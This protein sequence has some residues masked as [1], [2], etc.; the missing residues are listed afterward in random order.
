MKKEIIVNASK[1]RSRIAIVEDGEL[2]EL[3]VE[4]PD[5]VRTLG[6]IYLAR[7][8]KVMPAIRA[9]FVDIG[10]KQDAF[11]H[12]SDLTD[13]LAELLAITGDK[14]PGQKER[15]LSTAP[16]KRIAD[17]ADEPDVE[18]TLELD[19]DEKSRQGNRRSSRRGRSNRGRSH[20]RQHR[21]RQNEEEEEQEETA[22]ATPFV[23]DLT[24]KPKPPPPKPVVEEAKPEPEIVEP[25]AEAPEP[26]VEVK[27]ERKP[28]IGIG[29]I[30]LTSAA[31]SKKS[32]KKKEDRP[33]P[34]SE[35]RRSNRR[36]EAVEIEEED[37]VDEDDVVEA[38]ETDSDDNAQT[39]DEE[40]DDRRRGRRR[41]RRGGRRRGRRSEDEDADVSDDSSDVEEPDQTDEDEQPRQHS[42]RNRGGRGRSSSKETDEAQ[43]AEPAPKSN[44]R[45][46][47]S[48][49]SSRR[50][51]NDSR[52]QDRK[53]SG[54]RPSGPMARPDDMLKRDGRI[55]VKVTKEP[56][57]AKGSRVSTDISFAGRFLVLV[58]AADY[59]AV[60]KKIESARER[61]RLRTLAHSLKPDG[62]GV[63]VRTVATGKDAKTLDT[64]LSLLLDKWRKIEATLNAR[65]D[66]PE[67]LYEDVNM[68]SSI[69][70]DL[71]TDDFDRIVVDDP[72]LH[73]NIK[74][75]V[76]AV[77][78][79]MAEKVKLH[80]SNT[81]LFRAAGIERA[82]EQVFSSRV[83]LPSGGYLIVEHTEAMHVVDVN[84]GRAGKGKTQ[85]ENLLSVNLEAAHEVARQLR[86]RDLGGII[87]ID[88][89]DMYHEGDRRK[90]YQALKREFMKDRA[91]TKLLPMS[92]F[93]LIEITR[94]RLRPSITAQGADGDDASSAME[95]AGASEI[96]QPKRHFGPQRL[97]EP[98]S[99]E[100]IAVHID[101]WLKNYSKKVNDRY[102]DRPVVIRVHPLLET[103]LKKGIFNRMLKWRLGVKGIKFS[104]E[105]NSALHPLDFDACDKKS[106]KS[107]KARFT[108]KQ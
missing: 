12:F 40:Y 91:V 27:E 58:P 75:Y 99:H 38:V 90:V 105:T 43:V 104:F 2:A 88:F 93:G 108:P 3:Y 63:I 81:P 72:K 1:D 56:I 44:G 8:R 42:S 53:S 106:G 45:S 29:T 85:A 49:S 55:L 57:S 98:V 33:A 103:Y 46:S 78:P 37:L 13:N 18:D 80:R 28:V 22:G 94:Q 60:S 68:V 16:P 71:F 67:L 54:N 11:L 73:R 89:I 47:S 62:F 107:L 97:D 19:E 35:S 5:N 83:A 95:A 79:Q 86:L 6:N 4:H 100:E 64:D 102:R 84:S 10:Q 65:P 34:R 41:G 21:R 20:S 66:P 36:P 30:D 69:I 39:D 61:R 26:E 101:A 7:I 92:D 77:A 59:V 24:A 74:A 87:V 32:E 25:E 9:A 48:R 17:D 76:Q 51:Q 82:V 15:V 31:T 50:P 70:R 52:K 14:V 96:V 23:I